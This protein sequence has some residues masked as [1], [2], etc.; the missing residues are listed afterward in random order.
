MNLSVLLTN[1]G[2]YLPATVIAAVVLFAIR[3]VLESRRRRASERRS[4]SALK[5][6]FAAEC[7]RNL[8]TL[9]SLEKALEEADGTFDAEPPLKF[10]THQTPSG[11]YRWK[12]CYRNNE[13]KSGGVLPSVKRSAL[14]KSVLRV[15]ELNDPLFRAVEEAIE[16]ISELEHLRGSLINFAQ[17]NDPFDKTHFEG[18]PEWALE[19]LPDIRASL[20][21][22]YKICTGR[23]LEKARLR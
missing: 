11:E 3:E 18:F 22:L 15:A 4:I 12:T 6:V 14:D 8:W 21:K 19:Q 9:T 5:Q 23:Q 20:D 1:L 17:S 16:A 10:V 2:P 13:L 7:E